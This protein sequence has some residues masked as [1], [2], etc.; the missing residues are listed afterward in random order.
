MDNL[1]KIWSHALFILG[2]AL[3]LGKQA[4]ESVI[5]EIE[6]S[7]AWLGDQWMDIGRAWK[8]KVLLTKMQG[9]NLSGQRYKRHSYTLTVYL[10]VGIVDKVYGFYVEVLESYK[11]SPGK[12]SESL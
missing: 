6:K 3:S 5:V 12:N 1:G 7:K 4:I 9:K 8:F 11:D 10:L 2:Y